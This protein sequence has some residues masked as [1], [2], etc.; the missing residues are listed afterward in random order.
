[1]V[2]SAVVGRTSGCRSNFWVQPHFETYKV[3]I[4]R[5]GLT[6]CSDAVSWVSSG[7][8]LG[9]CGAF[10]FSSLGTFFLLDDLSDLDLEGL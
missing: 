6:V 10:L 2:T 1:M 7:V 4:E 8:A 3:L 9:E 5:K